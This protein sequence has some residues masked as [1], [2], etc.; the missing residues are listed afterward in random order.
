MAGITGLFQAGA[1]VR[2]SG[3]VRSKPPGFA[4]PGRGG[5]RVRP[6]RSQP[7][8]TPRASAA[9][10]AR[11]TTRVTK[12]SSSLKL[13]LRTTEGDT[14][15][16]SLDALNSNQTSRAFAS[17]PEGRI[18]QKTEARSSSLSASVSVT[19]D[20]SNA[21]LVDIKELLQSLSSGGAPQAGVGELDTVSAYQYSYQHAREVSQA[22][23][24]LYG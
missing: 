4:P 8:D 19:G 22:R 17:G 18:Q 11:A 2:E 21:E 13:T 3:L 12:E 24:E 9:T 6:E 20:L 15:E 7:G 5:G 16:I 1:R 10:E 14:V 23:V